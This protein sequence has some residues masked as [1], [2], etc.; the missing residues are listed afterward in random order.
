MKGLKDDNFSTEVEHFPQFDNVKIDTL[1]ELQKGK[2]SHPYNVD[3]H[4]FDQTNNH[5]RHLMLLDK[6]E[7]CPTHYTKGWFWEL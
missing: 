7:Q 5:S 4:Y 1:S 6:R 2:Y 3:E